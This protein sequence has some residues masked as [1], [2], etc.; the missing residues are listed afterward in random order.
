MRQTNRYKRYK[1]LP[2]FWHNLAFPGLFRKLAT[3]PPSSNSPQIR[4]PVSEMPDTVRRSNVDQSINLNTPIHDRE[5]IPG[6]YVDFP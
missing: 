2:W 3:E 1:N 6:F 5:N 4:R